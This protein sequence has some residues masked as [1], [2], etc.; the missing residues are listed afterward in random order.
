MSLILDALRGGRP[1]AT[2]R[3]SNANAAQTD[4][5]LQTLGYGHFRT[6]SVINR[7]KRLFVYLLAAILLAAAVWGAAI[8]VKSR[9]FTSDARA[10]TPRTD[11]PVTPAPPLR[12]TRA[13]EPRL[14]AVPAA[15]Q[16]T[17]TDDSGVDE[18]DRATRP[19]S[20]ASVV[21]ARGA[22]PPA[23]SPGGGPGSRPLAGQTASQMPPTD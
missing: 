20:S 11:L 12:R 17:T 1:R 18:R 16:E 21:S 9:Y 19:L 14:P 3:P 10:A 2:P 7:I 6:V 23:L 13:A 8:W 5:V 15:S 4:A 22:E